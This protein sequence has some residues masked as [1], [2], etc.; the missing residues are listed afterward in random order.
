MKRGDTITTCVVPGPG[1]SHKC[2]ISELK[3]AVSPRFSM[4]TSAPR[5]KT[6]SPS[7]TTANSSP[8]CRDGRL[9]LRPPEATVIITASNCPD[10]PDGA[11]DSIR[12]R[13]HE[14]SSSG[15]LSAR[16]TTLVSGCC[17]VKNPA[18]V[19]P[20]V[21]AMRSSDAI[22]GETSPF[23]IWEMK[24][25]E[26]PAWAASVRTDMPWAVRRLRTRLPTWIC[27][28]LITK[29]PLS[30]PSPR[31]Y[32]TLILNTGQSRPIDLAPSTAKRPVEKQRHLIQ[33]TTSC[34]PEHSRRQ[35][36]SR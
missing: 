29:N 30:G 6:T 36:P 28:A 20:R 9:P 25:G 4:W 15:R 18:R 2:G 22:E 5:V 34:T 17:S 33:R 10:I 35:R 16:V 24:L 13:D 27:S 8:E 23:S 26:K 11:R 1:F 19:T 31:S 32:C 21:E 12:A 14:L 3:L 7:K